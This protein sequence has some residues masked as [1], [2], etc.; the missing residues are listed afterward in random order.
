[1]NFPLGKKCNLGPIGNFQ[2]TTEYLALGKAL[3]ARLYIKVRVYI[4]NLLSIFNLQKSHALNKL[5][6]FG[7]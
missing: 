7:L 5:I 1:M 4:T 6:L 2:Y 3:L